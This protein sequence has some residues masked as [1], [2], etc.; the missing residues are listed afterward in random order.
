MYINSLGAI[1]FFPGTVSK[2]V[3]FSTR[4]MLDGEKPFSFASSRIK[5]PAYNVRSTKKHISSD[6]SFRL[7]IV[8]VTLRTSAS[9]KDFPAGCFEISVAIKMNNPPLFLM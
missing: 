8:N 9:D 1:A 2:K 6:F 3:V 4:W 7:R 5:N